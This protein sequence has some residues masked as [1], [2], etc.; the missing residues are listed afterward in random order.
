[1]SC[2]V[3][4]VLCI[5]IGRRGG[6]G[7]GNCHL[8]MFP[9]A[10]E[11]TIAHRRLLCKGS[12]SVGFWWARQLSPFGGGL[13]KGLHRLTPPPEVESPPIPCHDCPPRQA[14]S[15]M[16]G[17][18]QPCTGCRRFLLCGARGTRWHTRQVIPARR[19]GHAG[20]CPGTSRSKPPRPVPV[21]R[22]ATLPVQ[23]LWVTNMRNSRRELCVGGGHRHALSLVWQT[24]P[25]SPAS[26]LLPCTSLSAA[27]PSHNTFSL[28]R[29]GWL[30]RSCR[31]R[32]PSQT[33]PGRS[34]GENEWRV[35]M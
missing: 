1:M 30:C 17:P 11:D 26:C 31:S 10:C 14:Q 20:A 34:T 13:T 2:F 35:R 12:V 9:R 15:G 22:D 28:Q 29:L 25:P 18:T 4:Q 5:V 24:L 16:A 23:C 19:H 8:G 33:Q 21:S 3:P 32:L 6:G 27:F 7:R